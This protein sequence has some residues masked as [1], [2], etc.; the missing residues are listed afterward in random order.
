[1]SAFVIAGVSLAEAVTP[2]GMPKVLLMV[3]AAWVAVAAGIAC[4]LAAGMQIALDSL[5]QTGLVSSVASNLMQLAWKFTAVGTAAALFYAARARE[6][7]L[8]KV[9]RETELER[10]SLQRS[11]MASRLSVLRAR[12]EPEF[13]FDAL[14]EVQ[15]LYRTDPGAADEMVDALIDYLR[16]A[17][18]QMRG[19]VS[20]IGR[21][22]D[23][24]RAYVAVLE[25]SR[26]GALRV[27][28]RTDL[29]VRDEVLPPMVLMPLAQAA[30]CGE[31]AVLR[32]WFAISAR[33]SPAGPR[34]IIEIE[35]GG[36]PAAWQGE[37]PETA[38]R[39]LTAYYGTGVTLE[40]ASDT[41]V[42]RVLIRLPPSAEIAPPAEQRGIDLGAATAAPV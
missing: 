11:M 13:L 41:K 6:L 8:A 29:D 23:L 40:F 19:E 22:I 25:V 2:R 28:A 14:G 24:V 33:G 5:A 3:L 36:R 21:E 30:F 38:S 12:V 20:T 35:G 18:P 32:R 27:D 31:D 15:A 16:A 17:L 9:V 39:T 1:M 34:V 26:G 7:S 42:H 10:A 4:L 37:G